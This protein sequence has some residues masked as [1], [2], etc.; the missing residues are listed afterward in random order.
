MTLIATI[1]L[2]TE[3]QATRLLE[4]ASEDEA[5]DSPSA[6]TTEQPDL[7]WSVDLYFE[8]KPDRKA[9]SALASRVL[10]PKAPAFTVKVL[11]DEDW[12]AKSLEGL[13]PVRAGRFL[14]HG[15][16]DRERIRPNDLAIE[17]EAGQAFGTGHHGTTTGCLIEIDRLARSRPIRNALDVGTGTG[18]LAIGIA[19]RAKTPVLA[20]DIDPVAVAVAQENIRLNGVSAFVRTVVAGTLDKAE[21]RAAAPFDLIVANI[22]AGPLVALAPSMTRLVAPGGTI[23]LS[24]LLSAQKRQVVAAYRSLGLRLVRATIIEDWATLVLGK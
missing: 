2:P 19:E 17:I 10:G 23:I 20:S 13:K 24:G 7:S 21:F 11:P 22:L 16:H 5:L 15:S 8:E 14:V 1:R 6:A 12:V 18:V 3:A 9:L 4:A